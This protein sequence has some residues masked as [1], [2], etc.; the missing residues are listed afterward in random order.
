M[1]IHDISPTL[2]PRTA[3]WP[4]DVALRRETSMSFDDG[5]HMALS[6]FQTTVHIGA[7]ADAP[8]H[9]DS[10]GASIEQQELSPYLGECQ[11]ISVDVSRGARVRPEQLPA[12]P[13]AQR[14][15]LRT[16]T[17]PDPE[18]FNGDFAAL[19]PELIEHL[20]AHGVVLVGL[21][22]PSVDL[23]HDAQML[24]HKAI[25]RCGMRILEGLVLNA[26]PDGIYTLIALPLPLE[27]ADASPVRAVLVEGQLVTS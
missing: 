25:A 27:G 6:S 1:N 15:L 14:L 3:V 18:F 21:D 9:Y 7:H 22:T 16:N 24:S 19:S 11:V 8:S 23:C 4:G 17:F 12:A 13:Y 26:V 10:T 20:H 5:H 2:S